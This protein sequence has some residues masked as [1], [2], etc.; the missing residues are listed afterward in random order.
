[1]YNN[2]KILNEYRSD[3]ELK[4]GLG[5]LLFLAFQTTIRNSI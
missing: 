1:M 5:W 4:S 3:N 2:K